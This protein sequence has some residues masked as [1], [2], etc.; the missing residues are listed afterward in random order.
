MSEATIFGAHKA[1][2]D[3]VRGYIKA[4]PPHIKS[5]PVES[6]AVQAE[7]IEPGFVYSGNGFKV[8]A[9]Y[10]EHHQR[11]GMPSVGYRVESPDGVVAI[12]GDTS[13]C[14]GM[15]ELARGADVLIH[16]TAFLDEIIEE[17]QMWSHSG[18]SG[19]GRVAQEAGVKKL[20]LTHLGP[21]TS[22][23]P[24]V[25]MASMYYGERRSADVWD[26]IV[27]AAKRN[28]T[29]PVVLAHDAMVIDIGSD[30]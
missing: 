16:D 24:A 7:D 13:P 25:D 12:S 17:R 8:I 1:D 15:I 5:K 20:V 14:E 27:K 26:E 22:A 4:L 9:G 19:A 18:P 3:F 6:P 11:V 2:V 21:Y 29:G 28:Y 23:Q 10:V 30:K